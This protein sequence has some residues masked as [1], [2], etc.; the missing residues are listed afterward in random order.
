[1]DSQCPISGPNG[2]PA[3]SRTIMKPKKNWLVSSLTL[4]SAVL[5]LLT[6]AS[7]LFAVQDNLAYVNMVQDAHG[8]YH[9]DIHR[10]VLMRYP[11]GRIGLWSIDQ[12]EVADCV[13]RGL[14]LYPCIDTITN[15]DVSDWRDTIASDP[16]L[17]KIKYRD[18]V[19]AKGSTVEL[20]VTPHVS[21]YRYHLSPGANFRA[22]TLSVNEAQIHSWDNKVWPQWTNNTFKVIDSRTVEA[23]VSGFRKAKVY[24]YIK[25]NAATVGNG[26]F[27]GSR[28]NDGSNSITGDDIGGYVKVGTNELVAAVAVS[29]TSMEQARAY[30]DAEFSDMN[31]DAAVARLKQAWLAKLGKIEAQGPALR[32]R[33]L[34]T[35]LYTLYVNITDVSDNP[36]YHSRAPLLSI[37]SSDFWQYVGGY[38]RCSWDMSRGAYPVL[39]L[40]DPE[41][42]T[43]ILNTYQTQFDRDGK[44][45]GDWD[46]FTNSRGGAVCFIQNIGLLAKLEGVT[47]VDYA[48]L[49]DSARISLEK[50][51]GPDFFTLGYC[52]D[53]HENSGSHT[54]EHCTEVQGLAI[55]A[56]TLGDT[57]TYDKFYACRTNYKNLYDVTNKRFRVKAADGSWGPLKPT[58]QGFFEGSGADYA[59]MAP[60]DPY[61]LLELRG[62]AESVA[63]IE[64]YVTKKSD[65]NDYKLIY[66]YVPIFADR[67]DVTQNL[68]RNTHVPKFDH[69]NMSEGFWPG[70]K[71]CYYTDNAGALL[72]AII[73]LYWIPTSGATWMLTAPSVDRLVIH[74]RTDITIQ[75][76]NNSPANCY[77]NSIQLNGA[78]Y[79]AFLISGKT[80][81]AQKQALTFSLS[82][83]PSKIGNLYL[84]SADGEVL[85]AAT[86][87]TPDLEFEIDPM[88]ASCE[89]QVYSVVKPSAVTLNGLEFANWTYNTATK[90]ATLKAVTKGTYRVTVGKQAP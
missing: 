80:L 63:A 2:S 72:S 45:A 12:G 64:D 16:S 1:M 5:M 39:S 56:R 58:V 76:L 17:T 55:L 34:Y 84:S 7:T 24:Y 43:H 25:F 69:L 88:A 59:F 37:A 4:M 89:A 20:T 47:G 30:F 75:T 77:I 48:R 6:A 60:Q 23:S 40:I 83:R 36:Y 85:G 29:H 81:T 18:E 51:C 22:I 28:V 62:A 86:V 57:A 61:G 31:F 27:N 67:A 32:M 90:L 41:V 46:P 73:G 54:L 33:Q 10:T 53:K 50:S 65:F 74:G 87:R 11:C 21:C 19:P 70:S 13:S 78:K 38:M 15:K 82:D 79:P 44:F 52:T 68:V 14:R 8:V 42:F 49:K 71:G 9:T 3:V 35:A 66:E 26:T